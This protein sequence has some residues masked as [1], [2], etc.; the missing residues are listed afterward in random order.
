MARARAADF[1]E[2]QLHI[3]NNAAAVFAELGMEKASM[4]QVAM[5]SQVSKAL[6]YHYYPSKGAL[7]FDII[8]SHLEGLGEAIEQ[9]IKESHDDLPEVRLRKIVRQILDCYRNADN[10]HQVQLN[11][12]GSLP[13]EEEQ[14]IK[15]LERKI[16]L[17]VAETIRGINPDINVVRPLLKPVTMSL[18][19]MLN[20]FYMWFKDDGPISREEYADL[21][22]TL[23]LEGM[24]NIQ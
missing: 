6:L 23:I 1:E 12:H 18:F 16:V 4:A 11:Y 15:M 14:E 13:V 24:R 10:H 3:L 21:V 19:G 9:K 5:R 7:I 20:W 2:K 17:L 22:T 8:R